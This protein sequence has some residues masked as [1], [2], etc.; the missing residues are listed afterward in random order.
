MYMYTR[1]ICS[2]PSPPA[3]S[4]CTAGYWFY[5]TST[6]SIYVCILD[7]RETAGYSQDATLFLLAADL[8]RQPTHA[9]FGPRPED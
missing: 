9:A 3:P 2:V 8:R 6:N 5:S 1:V 4:A 7:S